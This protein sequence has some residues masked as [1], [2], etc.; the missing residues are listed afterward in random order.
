MSTGNLLQR[1]LQAFDFYQNTLY[2]DLFRNTLYMDLFQNRLYMDLFRNTLYMDLFRNRRR[3]C[4]DYIA[5]HV[6]PVHGF[7]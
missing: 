2:I 6:L 3:W 4:G 1:I 5:Q 7:F